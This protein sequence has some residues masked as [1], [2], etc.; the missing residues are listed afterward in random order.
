LTVVA[1]E[2][3]MAAWGFLRPSCDTDAIEPGV[4]VDGGIYLDGKTSNLSNVAWRIPAPGVSVEAG[5]RKGGGQL[6]LVG[7][8]PLLDGGRCEMVVRKYGVVMKIQ[9]SNAI[10]IGQA[11]AGHKLITTWYSVRMLSSDP[12]MEEQ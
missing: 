1:I 4:S 6:R 8:R 10:C 12:S 9:P 5:G 2:A 11:E 3:A 7:S